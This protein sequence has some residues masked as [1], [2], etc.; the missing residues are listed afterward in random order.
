MQCTA[1]TTGE[2][3]VGGRLA[4]RRT[5]DQ[6]I[7]RAWLGEEYRLAGLAWDHAAQF[8]TVGEQRFAGLV[9]QWED[10]GAVRRWQ[11]PVGQLRSGQ[12][13]ADTSQQR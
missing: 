13:A 10:A 1:T 8:F 6:S 9:Q 11:G 4:T 5:S 2:H 7:H 3:G 12:F